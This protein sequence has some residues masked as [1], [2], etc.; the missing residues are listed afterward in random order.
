[1]TGVDSCSYSIQLYS[2]ISYAYT[3]ANPKFIKRSHPLCFA[4]AN[5]VAF[6]SRR[7]CTSSLKMRCRRQRSTNTLLLILGGISLGYII[8]CALL[9]STCCFVFYASI[10]KCSTILCLPGVFKFR[11]ECRVLPF[12]LLKVLNPLN[13]SNHC[14]TVLYKLSS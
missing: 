14:N 2:E 11:P 5:N 9:Y 7:R 3:S 6:S 1:M 10:A 4:S 12:Y 8:V 13:T